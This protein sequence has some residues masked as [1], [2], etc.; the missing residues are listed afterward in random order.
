MSLNS[1][2][3]GSVFSSNAEATKSD[4]RPRHQ[5]EEIL[6]LWARKDRKGDTYYTGKLADG[7]CVLAF[8][9]HKEDKSTESPDLRVF[10]TDRKK[11]A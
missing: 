8:Y 11:P 10:K 7:T 6:A 1:Q 5:K 4:K 9:K 3:G 2:R